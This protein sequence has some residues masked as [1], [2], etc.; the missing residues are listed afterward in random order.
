LFIHGHRFTFKYL[1]WHSITKIL[2]NGPKAHFPFNQ[3]FLVFFGLLLIFSRQSFHNR[4]ND[5]GGRETSELSFEPVIEG[6]SDR[7][8]RYV[9]SGVAKKCVGDDLGAN[10]Y[11]EYRRRCPPWKRG[12][13]AT[14]GRTVR[15]LAQR[16]GFLSDKLDGA[17]VRRGDIVR[18]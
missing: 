5:V 11:D 4:L 8:L 6:R 17:R 7:S 1:C 16:L 12:W 13:S 14:E 9:P 18:Q 10:H 2:R 15:D 3:S